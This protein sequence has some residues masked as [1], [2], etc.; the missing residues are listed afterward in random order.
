MHTNTLQEA[1]PLAQVSNAR[2]VVMGEHLVAKD[3]IR[4]LRG[5]QKIHFEQT[6]LQ[7]TLLWFVVLECVE[8]E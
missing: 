5:V 4:N 2:S 7:M 3:S 8:Q 6:R 1:S